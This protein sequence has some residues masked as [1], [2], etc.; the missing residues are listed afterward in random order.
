GSP[1]HAAFTVTRRVPSPIPVL[2]AVPHAGRVY[3]PSLLER[4]RDPER[5]ALRLEDRYADL[6]AGKIAEATGAALIVARAPRAMIDLNRAPG[7]MDWEMLAEGRPPGQMLSRS[8]RRARG[9]LG[10]VPRRLPGLG[11][12]WKGRM[13][14][15]DLEERISGVHAPYH[16]ALAA[17]LAA[18]RERW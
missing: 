11:E 5:A 15:A 12:I 18:L 16:A 7:E 9:G 8:G 1:G 10:L 17:E 14:Q 4:M 13:R 3:P 6:L 2:V